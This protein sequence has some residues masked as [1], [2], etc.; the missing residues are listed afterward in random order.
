M[1]GK[2]DRI[3][4]K[5]ISR[6][7]RNTLDCLKYVNRRLLD[8]NWVVH[9][10]TFCPVLPIGVNVGM[11]YVQDEKRK[12]PCKT[13]QITALKE[14]FYSDKDTFRLPRQNPYFCLKRLKIKDFEEWG[15]DL[16]PHC[17]PILIFHWFINRTAL[18]KNEYDLLWKEFLRGLL[19]ITK[20]V[21]LNVG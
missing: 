20:N 8:Y 2:I 10:A 13:G 12:I 11:I 17:T 9:K 6:F 18:D 15:W 7:A 4:T 5:S 19:L 3:I 1:A 21:G 16:Y 14:E